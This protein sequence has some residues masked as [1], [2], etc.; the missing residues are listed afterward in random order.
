MLV[1][2]CALLH[3]RS[4]S[5]ILLYGME[6]QE[7]LD[8]FFLRFFPC[9][10]RGTDEISCKKEIKSDEVTSAQTQTHIVHFP[11][12]IFIKWCSWLKTPHLQTLTQTQEKAHKHTHLRCNYSEMTSTASGSLHTE[13][14]NNTDPSRGVC[15]FGFC[16]IV[17]CMKA[18]WLISAITGI[19]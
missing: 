19:F 16:Y 8:E 13:H 9:S 7:T 18:Q 17:L 12:W 14:S 10:V 3:F 5:T 1:S 15:T 4:Y 11:P 6:R 2:I